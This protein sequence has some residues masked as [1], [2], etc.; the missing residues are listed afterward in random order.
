MKRTI[1]WAVLLLAMSQQVNADTLT[2]VD[3]LLNV[4]DNS[5]EQ[6]RTDTGRQ[7]LDIYGSSAVFF[8]DTPVIA[9]GMDDSH[10]N[11]TV[12]FGTA[13]FYTTCA[14]YAEA[15]QYI[16]RALP[17]AESLKPQDSN[18][19]ATLLCDKCYC[20]FKTSRYEQAIEAGQ[21][22]MRLAQ[23]KEDWMQLSRAHLYISLVNHALRK[24]DEAKALVVKAIETNKRLGLNVQTHNAL[25]IACE[26]FCS[27]MEVDKA[28]DYGKQAVEAAR[29]IDY[30]PGVANHLTQLA[31][32][33]D[34]KGDYALG[35][36]VADSAIAMVKTID[37]LDRNLL[38]LALEYKSWNF[39]DIGRQREAAEALREAIAL[40]QALG[41]THAVWYDYRTLSEALEAFDPHGSIEALKRYTRMGDSIH[42]EELKELMSKANAE[43]HNDELK[44]ENAESRRQSRIILWTA[45]F[46]VLSLALAIASLLYAFR[47]KNRTTQVLRRLMEVRE[48]FFVNVAHELRT[49]LT[50]ILGVA[51]KMLLIPSGS[52]KS[53][54]SNAG[55]PDS[56]HEQCKEWG[57]MIRR[58]GE[59]L[60]TL[61][62]QMLDI[63][64]VKS[65]LGEPS[66]TQGEFAS[67]VAMI[68]E[69]YQE[70]AR[71]K[72]VTLTYD[73]DMQGVKS[74]FAADYVQKVVGNLL[75]NGIKYTSEGGTVALHVT[76][77]DQKEF[78]VIKVSD[79]GTGIAP[80]HLPH[81]FEPF[82]RADNASGTGT[83]V[84]LALVKQIVDALGGTISV[85]SSLGQGTTFEV[86]LPMEQVG[87]ALVEHAAEHVMDAAPESADQ[88]CSKTTQ[89]ILIVEDNVD[90]ANLIGQQFAERYTVCYAA[91]GEEGITKTREL[92]PDLVITDLMMPGTDGLQ[93]CRTIRHD[94][95][96]D[97]IPIIVVTAKATEQD[98]IQGREAGA[99][100]YLYKPFNAGEL[101]VCVTQLLAT[102]ERLR[103]KFSFSA[104]G[105][106]ENAALEMPAGMEDMPPHEEAPVTDA[107]DSAS[108]SAFSEDF[109]RKVDEVVCQLMASR[110]ADVEH[111]AARLCISPYQLRSKLTAIT[112]LTPKKYILG[113]RLQRARQMLEE[114]PER[115]ISDVGES[116]GFYDK[117]H[118][119]RHFREAFGITPGN[120]VKTCV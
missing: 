75:S 106:T 88:V 2:D 6:T 90:V 45:V 32:A 68:V 59:E 12:W 111:V 26:I 61:V 91:N 67:Y 46:V 92:M 100:A 104:D 54:E 16:D 119:L 74:V 114:N 23:E 112:G 37:P 105:L 13:R 56:L 66:T 78:V 43:F 116:C 115:T 27:A 51:D 79:T 108:F 96:T 103:K 117:S 25:G 33:Y 1:L 19:L 76:A 17:L 39:I 8:N 24:Y 34:R 71:Q 73:T 102:R 7:L 47:Q 28:I 97:H 35:L 94:A 110:E 80:E 63:S 49:P 44:E 98:C 21:E 87:T 69:Y 85:E 5:H 83:G 62:N 29:A 15:L 109:I 60:L 82:C 64:K 4:Y 36:Q 93:L 14:H 99:D 50:V 77:P 81:V 101:D 120:F 89:S 52:D 9:D 86:R 3:S 41:N 107:A 48:D 40:Q 57:G 31:Y 55:V 20:L 113:V 58:Q 118:F 10:Q 53:T 65:A 70:L 11:L 22:A 30:Q 95:A 84:G 38:A 42:S 18:I 72:G